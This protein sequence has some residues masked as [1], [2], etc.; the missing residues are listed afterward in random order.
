MFRTSNLALATALQAI[1]S[2]KLEF[3]ESGKNKRSYFVFDHT[4][5]PLFDKIIAKYWSKQLPIDALT[6]FETL[7]NIKSRLYEK[8]YEK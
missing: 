2:S 1:S 4:K 5:D 3:I 7:K 8:Q 6:Y